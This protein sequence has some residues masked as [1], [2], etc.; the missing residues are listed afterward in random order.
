MIAAAAH[1]R[2]VLLLMLFGLVAGCARM[3]EAGMRARLERWFSV[4][5]TQ[6]F[7]ARSGCAAGM[8]ALVDDSIG[9]EMPVT[10]S[11]PEMVHAL[12][13]GGPAALDD[14]AQAPDAALIALA[15]AD[16]A[17]GYALRRAGLEGGQ[18]MNAALQQAFYDALTAPAA[19]LAFDAQEGMVILLDREK[20]LLIAAVGRK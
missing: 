4:G 11:A 15:N 13:R 3:D 6:Y 8:F 18:C 17:T 19:V 7:S 9:A 10:G 14:G 20:K 5:E 12:G 2:P 1:L 16:R